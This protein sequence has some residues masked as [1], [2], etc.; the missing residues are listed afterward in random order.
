MSFLEQSRTLWIRVYAARI[1]VATGP[2]AAAAADEAVRAFK[3]R[4]ERSDKVQPD[5]TLRSRTQP[6][7]GDIT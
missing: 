6:P 2:Q 5:P 4:F 1:P 3:Q 7:E